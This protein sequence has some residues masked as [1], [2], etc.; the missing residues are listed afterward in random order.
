VNNVPRTFPDLFVQNNFY[1]YVCLAKNTNQ[2]N[3]PHSVRIFQ[4]VVKLTF[5]TSERV[6]V[7]GSKVKFSGEFES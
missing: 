4:F 3:N 5:F 6:F 7:F 2:Y 1:I